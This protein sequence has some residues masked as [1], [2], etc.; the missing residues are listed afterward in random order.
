VIADGAV[1]MFWRISSYDALSASASPAV[2]EEV[3]IGI[4]RRLQNIPFFQI[5]TAA[6]AY[7]IAKRQAS[8]AAARCGEL[9]A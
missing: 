6:S 1:E 3:A 9:T 4:R 2:R 8:K 7:R 5:G